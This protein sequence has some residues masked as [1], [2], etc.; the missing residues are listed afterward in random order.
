MRPSSQVWYFPCNK[1][2]DKDQDDKLTKRVLRATAK[3]P[4]TLVAKYKVTVITSDVRGAGT[5]A[6][7]FVN[8]F[9]S[10]GDTGKKVLSTSGR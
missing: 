10:D 6:S 8:I 5:D 9:G 1:W 7:V 4:A 2:L 3:D